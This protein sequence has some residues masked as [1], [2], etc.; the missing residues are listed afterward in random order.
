MFERL[1]DEIDG[2]MERDPAARRR[3]EVVLLYQGFHAVMLYRLANRLWRREWFFLGRAVSQFARW[4]TGIEIHPGATIG[5]RFFID[6]GMGV[7]IGETAEV[8]DN[9]MLY[10]GVTLGGTSLERGTKRHPTIEDNVIVGAGAQIIGPIT[11][12]RCA[13]IGANAVVVKDVPEGATM[14]GQQ[15]EMVRLRQV[16][17]DA[18]KVPFVSYGMPRELA[19]SSLQRTVDGLMDNLRRMELR[20][21]QLEQSHDG[22]SGSAVNGDAASN[23]DAAMPPPK[24]AAG[25]D[26]WVMPNDRGML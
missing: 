25:D 14:V 6:H 18:D 22:T 10:H 2:I 19:V 17:A 20:M 26:G 21:K 4:L 1:Q 15:A 11:V 24:K 16:G 9:V 3:W 13:R 7:V 23:D 12:G 5:R 8:G